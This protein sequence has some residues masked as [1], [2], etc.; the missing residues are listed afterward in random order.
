ME[1]VGNLEYPLC[2]EVSVHAIFLLALSV[3]CHV[4]KLFRI[5]VDIDSDETKIEPV[6]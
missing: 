3:G 2:L 4:R 6:C 1:S 5:V